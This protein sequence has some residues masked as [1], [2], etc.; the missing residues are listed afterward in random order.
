[1]FL[2]QS[3]FTYFIA[4][5]LMG[6]KTIVVDIPTYSILKNNRS[7]YKGEES[8]KSVLCLPSCFSY[9][10]AVSVLSKLLET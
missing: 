9:N 4:N 5:F 8:Q 3:F 10:I 1:M 2:S 6:A 7:H